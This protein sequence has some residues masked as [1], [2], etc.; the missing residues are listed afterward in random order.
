MLY[1]FCTGNGIF[2]PHDMDSRYVSRS[3]GMKSLKLILWHSVSDQ[4]LWM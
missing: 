3:E 4:G 1:N 2:N